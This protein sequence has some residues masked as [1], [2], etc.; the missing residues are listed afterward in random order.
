MV[1]GCEDTSEFREF[2]LSAQVAVRS[3]RQYRVPADH[4]HR[5]AGHNRR[6]QRH[7]GSGGLLLGLMGGAPGGVA[8]VEFD[9]VVPG[10]A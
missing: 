7:L 3:S 1:D 10:S 4:R 9:D 5:L 2:D 6:A 8:A